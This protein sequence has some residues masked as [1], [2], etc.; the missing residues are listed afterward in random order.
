MVKTFFALLLWLKL[1]FLFSGVFVRVSAGP[2]LLGGKGDVGAVVCVL[3]L[4]AGPVVGW[5]GGEGEGDLAVLKVMLSA[6]LQPCS[7]PESRLHSC[8]VPAAAEA[9]GSYHTAA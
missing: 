3:A 6:L 8:H 2:F 9:I 5:E 7:C 4:V 1:F